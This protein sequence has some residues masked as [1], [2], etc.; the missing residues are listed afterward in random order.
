M[1]ALANV[2]SSVHGM[3]GLCTGPR[4]VTLG[5]RA[6]R[7]LARACCWPATKAS[8]AWALDLDLVVHPANPSASSNT[9]KIAFTPALCGAVCGL[10]RRY[11]KS[12]ALIT[13]DLAF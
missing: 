13:S 2:K 1:I 7:I 4:T 11:T 8:R 5:A 3:T 10:V 12:V 6:W 9:Q